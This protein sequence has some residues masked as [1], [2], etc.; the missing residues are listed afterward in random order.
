[1]LQHD[2]GLHPQTVRDDGISLVGH[3]LVHPLSR[4]WPTSRHDVFHLLK[5]RFTH[6]ST[7]LSLREL[8]DPSF[9]P[10]ASHFE[11]G[12]VTS[13]SPFASPRPTLLYP[14]RGPAI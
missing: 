3:G 11:P 12:A 14:L 1:M 9:L 8:G 4:Q 13:L 7:P 2:G 5:L 10:A 6:V